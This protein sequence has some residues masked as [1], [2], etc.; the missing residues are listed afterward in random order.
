MAV[1]KNQAKP[2]P[3][4][5][6]TKIFFNSMTTWLPRLSNKGSQVIRSHI[7]KDSYVT[8]NASRSK[9]AVTISSESF[10]CNSV[11]F[12]DANSPTSNRWNGH[13]A[14][15]ILGEQEVY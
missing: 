5:S 8:N 3:S 10:K 6:I 15:S 14:D 2:K 4:S 13:F 9:G 7:Y 11:L 1:V 12:P